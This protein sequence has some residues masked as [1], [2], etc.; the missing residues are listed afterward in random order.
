[1]GFFYKTCG[2]LKMRRVAGS[3]WTARTKQG[4][5]A[6]MSLPSPHL[7]VNIPQCWNW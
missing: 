1:M 4:R 7:A 6:V 2:E 3:R 5:H